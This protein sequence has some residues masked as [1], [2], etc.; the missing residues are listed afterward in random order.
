VIGAY[1]TIREQFNLPIGRFEGIEVP[2]ARIG[3]TL[4]WMNAMRVV[5]AGAVDAGEKPAVVSAIAKCW[6][7]EAMRRVVNDAMDISGGAGISKGP[8]NTLAASYQAIP[9]G[10]TVEGANILTRSMIVFGQGAIRCHPFALKEMQSAATRNVRAFDDAFFGHVDFVFTNV[11]RS[12][13]LALTGGAFARVPVGGKAGAVLKKLT[14]FS[15]SFALLGDAAMGT[16]G[17]S[18]KRKEKV[19]GRLADALA[20]MYIASASVNRF[21]AS[22]QKVDS[23]LFE[24]ATTEAL[25]ETQEA[26][27]GVLDNL[28]NRA[29]AT[30]LR[31]FVFP[32]GAR[33]RPP[34]DRLTAACARS[35][36]DG[37]ESRLR[38][39]SDMFVPDGDDPALGRLERAMQLT[40]SVEPLRKK[41]RDAQKAKILPR[42]PEL[43]ILDEAVGKNVLTGA[44]KERVLEAARARDDAIQVDD[45]APDEYRMQRA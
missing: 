17:G 36:L 13:V 18:L 27:R 1:A 26:L 40:L 19:T 33:L 28:P 8:R 35:L 37:A 11:G 15:A 9:I 5:T 34:R 2:L 43:S 38:L 16:L 3:G 42:E 14:R 12:L 10:I 45:Y 23:A 41:L 39:T 29:V 7:T 32:L 22:G 20:W 44:E 30:L 6:S 31:P 24:W 4:Y 21:V 25:Y